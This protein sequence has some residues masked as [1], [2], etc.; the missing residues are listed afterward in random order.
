M[1]SWKQEMKN[2]EQEMREDAIACTREELA[3]Y[4]YSLA[5][6]NAAGTKESVIKR[7]LRKHYEKMIDRTM[8]FLATEAEG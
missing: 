4:Q 6:L 7:G 5:C 1:K 2:W 8:A 3:Y